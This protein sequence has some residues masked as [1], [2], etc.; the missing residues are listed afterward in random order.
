MKALL[1]LVSSLILIGSIQFAYAAGCGGVSAGGGGSKPTTPGQPPTATAPP[2]PIETGPRPIVGKVVWVKGKFESIGPDK[3]VTTLKPDSFVNLHDT[4]VTGSGQA[5]IVFT[6]QTT[7]T[8]QKGTQMKVSKYE[9]KPENKPQG[10][11]GSYVM[12]LIEGG[13]RTVTGAIAKTNPGDYQVKTE[14]AIMGVRGTDYAAS[15]QGCKLDMKY[16][17]GTPYMTNDKGTIVL[18][19]DSPFATVPAFDKQ[20]VKVMKE[21]GVFKTPLPIIPA[22]FS[23]QNN[24]PPPTQVKNLLDKAVKLDETMNSGGGGKACGRGGSFSGGFD[25]KFH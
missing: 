15:F 20:P 18:T 9:Y 3:K 25:I 7:M 24:A 4:L 22:A 8:F 1:P 2:E 13:Y 23:L 5:Q 6:D 16:Y 10:S 17:S 21:P 11:V 19:K 14:I 12:D